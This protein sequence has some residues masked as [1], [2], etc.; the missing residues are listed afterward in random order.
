MPLHYRLS[1]LRSLHKKFV[2]E[3]LHDCSYLYFSQHCPYYAE[4][5]SPNDWGTCLC[6]TCLNPE[7]NLEALAKILND[8][9]F[10]WNDTNNCNAIKDFIKRIDQVK[11][12]KLITFSEWQ[13]VLNKNKKGGK[14]LSN[15]VLAKLNFNKFKKSLVKELYLM[16][17]H[18]YHVHSQFKAFKMARE[19]AQSNADVATLQLDWSE[20]AKMQRSQEEKSAYYHEYSACLY[21]MYIWTKQC[22]YSRTTISDCTDH[23]S[24]AIMTSI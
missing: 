1:S 6:R 2:A 12:D 11:C 23:K 20:N 13:K 19:E 18:Q 24:P 8:T 14:K 17:D 15:K 10:K 3:S 21:P 4:K 9:S 7:I 22:N 16:H 5:P